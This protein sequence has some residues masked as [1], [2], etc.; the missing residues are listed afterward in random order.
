MDIAAVRKKEAK[1][2]LADGSPDPNWLQKLHRSIPEQFGN[3]I[4]ISQERT[5][6]TP[7]TMF[8]QN[9]LELQGLQG[10]PTAQDSGKI[11]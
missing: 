5:W 8:A 11:L 3:R 10:W 9:T 6:I 1:Q 4:K 7:P 2:Y